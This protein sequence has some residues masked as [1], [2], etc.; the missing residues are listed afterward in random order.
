MV[1]IIPIEYQMKPE[2]PKPVDIEFLIIQDQN[3]T[4]WTF[5]YRVT[6]S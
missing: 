1:T 6:E 3:I 4:G 5:F 2:P